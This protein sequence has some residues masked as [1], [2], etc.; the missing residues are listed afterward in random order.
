MQSKKKSMETMPEQSSTPDENDQT[1]KLDYQL[2]RLIRVA[3]VSMLAAKV[4][5]D[6]DAAVAW[7]SRPNESLSGK[8]PIV[9]C[10]TET[11]AKQ[12]QRVLNA[13]EWGGSA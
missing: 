9:L 2:E 12:V 5:E 3:T 13:L 1:I 10:E 8:I 11:G 6:K 7:L 4:W